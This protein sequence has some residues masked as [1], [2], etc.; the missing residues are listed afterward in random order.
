MRTPPGRV[1]DLSHPIR[2]AMTTYP[3]LPGPEI[4]DHLTRERAE[5]TY[6]PGVPFQIGRIS[7][8]GNTGTYLDSPYH[9]YDGGADWGT[10]DYGRDNPF[11][12]ERAASWLVERGSALVGIDSVNIDDIGDPRRPAHSGLLAAYAVLP[13]P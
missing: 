2:H 12:T 10:A 1:V 13:G 6:G 3:G 7:M 5:E 11:L 8:I 9:R 4:T